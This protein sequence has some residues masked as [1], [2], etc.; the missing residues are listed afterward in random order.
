MEL[1][2]L[3]IKQPKLCLDPPPRTPTT[4]L[5]KQCLYLFPNSNLFLHSPLRNV[6]AQYRRWD[7]NAENFRAQNFNFNPRPNK[8]DDDDDEAAE[9]FEVLEEFIDGAWIFPVFRSFGWMLP[10]IISS[11]LITSGPK[12]FLM[13]LAVPLGQSAL[14]LV[15]QRIVGKKPSKPKRKAQT[16]RR[17]RARSARNVK[18]EEDEEE[19][20]EGSRT[21]S[22]GYQTWVGGNDVRVD[23]DSRRSPRYGGWDD[24]DRQSKTYKGSEKN[25]AQNTDRPQRSK[26]SRGGR[27]GETPLLLR[28]LIAVFPFLGS[29]TKIL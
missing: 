18:F 4:K 21:E 2:Q 15:F 19:T 10:A 17:P 16:R 5:Y 3:Q 29:W 11:L 26:L 28:L 7:S 1:K 20:N 6:Q 12:A 14:S 25:S 24:L 23:R 8:N 9:W 13:A 22:M 27:K